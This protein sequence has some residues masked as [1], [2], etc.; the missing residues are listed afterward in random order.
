M[1]KFNSLFGEMVIEI[2]NEWFSDHPEA[3][4]DEDFWISK[5]GEKFLNWIHTLPQRF[6]K[7]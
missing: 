5:D 3:I 2:Q 4:D 7:T 6:P 1:D